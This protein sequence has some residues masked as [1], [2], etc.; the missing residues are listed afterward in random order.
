MKRIYLAGSI[1]G[2]PDPVSWRKEAQRMLAPEMVGIDPMDFETSNLTPRELVEQDLK[3][4]S[5][6]HG[7]ILNAARCSWGSAME[8]FYAKYIPVVAFNVPAKNVSLWL[9]A[10]IT[11]MCLDL[12]EAVVF[13][14]RILKNAD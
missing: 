8:I 9:M 14:K 11:T 1:M 7:I 2:D 12:E 3:L 6:C 4:I 13:T 10:H 5:T